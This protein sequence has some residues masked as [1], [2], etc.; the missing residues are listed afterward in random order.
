MQRSVNLQALVLFASM[1]LVGAAATS[2]ANVIPLSGGDSNDGWVAL[3]TSSLVMAYNLGLGAVNETIQGTT[4]TA[5][6]G[7]R[8]CAH[9]TGWGHGYVE[10]SRSVR[11]CGLPATPARPQTILPCR[12]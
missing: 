1:V 9:A 8:H 6:S 11:L 3:P 10:F 12:R 2:H 7:G 5:G 4:F